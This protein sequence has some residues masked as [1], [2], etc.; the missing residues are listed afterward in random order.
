[1]QPISQLILR[2]AERLVSGPLY[3][4]D[5]PPDDLA[6]RLAQRVDCVRICTTHHGDYRWFQQQGFNA[7][8]EAFPTV[9]ASTSTVVL[10]LPR[11]KK[12]LAM[13]LHAIASGADDET[14]LWIAGE[15]RAGIKSAPTLVGRYFSHVAKLDNARHCSL[16]EARR[17]LS[18]MPFTV[19]GY[20][21]YWSYPCV[22]RELQIASLPG[23]FAHGRLDAG[24]RLLLQ[25][26]E[27]LPVDGSVLDFA[28]GSGVI[29]ASVLAAQQT[30]SL[31][32]TCLDVSALAIAAT[33]ATLEANGMQAQLLPSDGLAEL[34][35]RFDWIIS[36]PPFHRGVDSDLD[37]AAD[38]FARAGTFLAENGK[39]LIV[40]NRHLPYT[41]WLSTHFKQ[42]E[43]RAQSREFTVIMASN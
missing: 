7:Q 34:H 41:R 32:L 24:S 2:S 28:C 27:D 20:F 16:F 4:V 6:S 42:A 35:G 12:R 19:S 26:I 31:S 11:E 30:A 23:V 10:R 13:M 8:F 9:P 21:D 15:K 40:F 37:I 38:F 14:C 36:N 33:R 25:A 3:L 39:M 5:P 1:M 17:S 22:R 29:G 18:G 43:T